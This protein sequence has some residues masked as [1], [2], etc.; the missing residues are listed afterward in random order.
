MGED[1]TG[2]IKGRHTSG[3]ALS[4]KNRGRI[5]TSNAKGLSGEDGGDGGEE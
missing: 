1:A 4:D 5:G 2:D 3:G